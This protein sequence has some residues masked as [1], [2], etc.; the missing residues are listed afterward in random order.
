MGK[1][2]EWVEKYIKY[3]NIK[4]EVDTFIKITS[5]LP[6]IFLILGLILY[7]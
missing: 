4:I 6:L 3:S 2:V 5:T 7:L 1:Y